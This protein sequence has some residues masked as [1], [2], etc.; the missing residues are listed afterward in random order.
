MLSPHTES[1]EGFE[2]SKDSGGLP[3]GSE[4]LPDCFET[5]KAGFEFPAGSRQKRLFALY[6]INF[7]SF[8][9]RPLS[10]SLSLDFVIRLFHIQSLTT[11][12]AI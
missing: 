7:V 6:F 2:G 11:S 12:F 1:S 3:A 5:L 8:A 9:K 4:A 10:D